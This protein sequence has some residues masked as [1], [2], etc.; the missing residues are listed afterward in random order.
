M[1]EDES[2]KTICGVSKLTLGGPVVPT[3]DATQA[4][5]ARHR[6]ARAA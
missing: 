4:A 3:F 2:R 1:I 6:S 5:S